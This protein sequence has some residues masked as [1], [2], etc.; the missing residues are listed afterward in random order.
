MAP[1]K[2]D[3][4][5]VSNKPFGTHKYRFPLVESY[6]HSF[7]FGG[8][9]FRFRLRFSFRFIFIFV[10]VFIFVFISR[11]HPPFLSSPFVRILF[12]RFLVFFFPPLAKVLPWPSCF[13]TFLFSR[14]LVSFFFFLCKPRFC[15][16]LFASSGFT[17]FATVSQGSAL[18]PIASPLPSSFHPSPL[19]SSL[20]SPYYVCIIFL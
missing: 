18:A 10:F 8:V 5:S 15:L 20:C 19:I 7:N 2:P 6:W 17:V 13:A 12:P 1:L 4:P 11:L 16:G 3:S 9:P 14:F